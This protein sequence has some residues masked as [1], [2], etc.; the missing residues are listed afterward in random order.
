MYLYY[1]IDYTSFGL[2]IINSNNII[3]LLLFRL[4]L[5]KLIVMISISNEVCS[6]FQVPHPNT[7]IQINGDRFI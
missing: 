2:V 4:H 3:Q 7:N 6:H 5:S 1:L